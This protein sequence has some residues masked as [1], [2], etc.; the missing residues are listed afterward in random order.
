MKEINIFYKAPFG[1]L[2]KT[3]DGRKAVFVGR[4]SKYLYYLIVEGSPKYLTYYEYGRR[5]EDNDSNELSD[6][7]IVGDWDFSITKE[8][9][10]TPNDIDKDAFIEKACDA[11][12]AI[13]ETKECGDYG[14]CIWV[15]KFRKRLMK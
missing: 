15:E 7:D 13:C 1:K 10:H 11:Y 12:C 8:K 6:Y 4:K 5:F 2:Y 3:R 14:E 9:F